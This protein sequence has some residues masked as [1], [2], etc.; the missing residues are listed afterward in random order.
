MEEDG[1]GR[2]LME[3]YK[4]ICKIDPNA[5]FVIHRIISDLLSVTNE[6]AAKLEQ[7]FKK[8]VSDCE[9]TKR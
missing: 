8:Y 4:E 9:K 3:M 6:E 2:E 7:L 1:D 5:K